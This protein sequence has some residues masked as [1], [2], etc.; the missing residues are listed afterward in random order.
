MKLPLS[1]AAISLLV[2]S[3]PSAQVQDPHF[4]RGIELQKSGKI[5]QAIE[6][7]E[8]SV[9]ASPRYPVLANL[10][11]A[12]ASLGRYQEAIACYEQAL[13]LAP[14]QPGIT[15]NLGL[16]HYKT[17]NLQKAAGLFE[18]VRKLDPASVQAQILLADCYFQLGDYARVIRELEPLEPKRPDDRA[19]AY[20]LGTAY[21]RD[22][23]MEKGQRL[24]DR[25]LRNGDSAEARLMMGTALAEV[26]KNKEAIAEFERA[27]QLNP[28]I[29]LAHSSLG[30]ALIRSG[31][32]EAALPHFEEELK[33]N[34]NDFTANF[35]AGFLRRR[36]N[37]DEEALPYLQ[38]ALQ[39]RPGN[40]TTAFQM[41]LIRLQRGELDEAQRILED[42]V[43]RSPE[44][45]DAH[46]TLARI[47]YRKK[48]KAE[49]DREQEIVEKLRLEQQSREPGS[50][51]STEL[52]GE[53]VTGRELDRREIKP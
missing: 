28:K 31:D 15:L 46:V 10:G 8:L 18:A 25:I 7:Y 14:G 6:Q 29:P 47:Y 39:L 48:M 21:L 23:Q 33:I 4:A 34:P 2:C 3:V 42:I 53:D 38:K 16:A 37:K 52:K 45:I 35:Y 12:Y 11:S 32:R 27:I 13:K 51:K 49:G 5:E 44:Y 26:Q 41:S 24:V 22:K 36:S 40:E 30:L 17:G 19:I 50:Q 43:R 1:C 9:K 20:L